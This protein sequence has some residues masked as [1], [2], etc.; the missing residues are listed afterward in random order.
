MCNAR[1][2][3]NTVCSEG[4][5][6]I[7]PRNLGTQLSDSVLQPRMPQVSSGINLQIQYVDRRVP[8]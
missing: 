6:T 5:D 3:C 2:V 1:N 4:G 7:L 8:E